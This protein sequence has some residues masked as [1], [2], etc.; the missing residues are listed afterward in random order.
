ME[1]KLIN[2]TKSFGNKKVILPT[3]LKISV[4][5]FGWTAAESCFRARH[6]DRAVLYFV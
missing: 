6:R 5:A 3:T 1:I 2:V 4:S